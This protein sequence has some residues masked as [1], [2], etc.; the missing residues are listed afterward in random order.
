VACGLEVGEICKYG[1]YNA[2]CCIDRK[3]FVYVTKKIKN[4]D[5]EYLHSKSKLIF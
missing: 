5:T 2:L 4:S 1:H 3:L